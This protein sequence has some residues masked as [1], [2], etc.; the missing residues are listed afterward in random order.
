MSWLKDASM[1]RLSLKL[2][3]KKGELMQPLSNVSMDPSR[4]PSSGLDDN[5]I[6]LIENW[7]KLNITG[8]S[9]LFQLLN[10]RLKKKGKMPTIEMKDSKG[11]EGGDQALTELAI[12][13]SSVNLPPNFLC[14]TGYL[15]ETVFSK[16]P[17]EVLR[18]AISLIREKALERDIVE[19]DEDQVNLALKQLKV[20]F[21][22]DDIQKAKEV[23]ED[24]EKVTCPSSDDLLLENKENAFLGRGNGNNEG[25]KCKKNSNSKSWD[26]E[27]C[28]SGDKQ[29]H[30]QVLLE[31]VLGHVRDTY[32]RG[33][34]PSPCDGSKSE[35]SLD[36]DDLT[37]HL[38]SP[39]DSV[40]KDALA[41]DVKALEKGT[42]FSSHILRN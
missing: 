19:L 11:K 20:G 39:L 42:Q 37:S 40:I 17:N 34:I 21:F 22:V 35:S 1:A 16:P 14:D 2:R 31:L 6:E 8:R 10:Y 38:V 18:S 9:C 36:V 25:D 12:L 41:T 30:Y 13:S 26:G 3:G 15:F 33:T 32:A 5:E 24:G 29:L 4:L 7:R 27:E 28:G 23:H